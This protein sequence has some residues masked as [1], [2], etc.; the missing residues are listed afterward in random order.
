MTSHNSIMDFK[1]PDI[2]LFEEC[3]KKYKY[4]DNDVSSF[5]TFCSWNVKFDAL[6]NALKK[7]GAKVL[8]DIAS[9]RGN[10]MNR[11]SLLRFSKVIGIEYDKAQFDESVIR[12]KQGHSK[13]EITFINMSATDP[14]LKDKV[15]EQNN[16]KQIDLV[17]CNFAL[18]YFSD[19]EQFFKSLSNM[20][21][22]GGIFLGTAADGDFIDFI[23]RKF[24]PIVDTKLYFMK[25]LNETEYEFK[26]ISP[27]FKQ[28]VKT[29]EGHISEEYKTIIEK[30]LYKKSLISTL[31]K[32][33]FV[34]YST[35]NGVPAIV[36]LVN[37]PIN[38]DPKSGFY[39]KR[40]I[41][42]ATL[43]FSFSFIKATPELLESVKRPI[44]LSMSINDSINEVKEKAIKS[45]CNYVI[46]KKNDV[47][48]PD[49]YI[50]YFPVNTILFFK[51][52]HDYFSERR[53]TKHFRNFRNWDAISVSIDK[54]DEIKEPN[55]YVFAFY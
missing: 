3:L 29:D 27:Y 50:S 39:Y 44:C 17:S 33:G 6:R 40:H 8:V 24:G 52:E 4:S 2:L 5:K 41:D 15:F 55:N 10:D 23:F 20:M 25:K 7:T 45:G 9:G 11:W 37:Y 34:P 49:F 13:I 32:Y 14:K 22:I 51:E 21:S 19:S 26:L 18:N 35:K 42:L 53:Y 47:V 16:K 30:F 46:I 36:N 38:K 54:L 28:L 31:E 12:Y 1:E 43:Y 48:V